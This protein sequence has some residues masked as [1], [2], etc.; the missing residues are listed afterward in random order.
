MITALSQANSGHENCIYGNNIVI[1]KWLCGGSAV[2]RHIVVFT[3]KNYGDLLVIHLAPTTKGS[4]GKISHSRRF[5]YKNLSNSLQKLP[6]LSIYYQMYNFATFPKSQFVVDLL[7][8]NSII[9]VYFP[10]NY[11]NLFDI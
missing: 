9:Y 6:K 5:V 3:P 8:L 4:R 11:P 7:L 1:L 10:H 2:I